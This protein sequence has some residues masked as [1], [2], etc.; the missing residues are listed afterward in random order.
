MKIAIVTGGNR[1]I[2]YEIVRGLFLSGQF[3]DVYLTARTPKDGISAVNALMKD[4]ESDNKQDISRLRFHQ[5]DLTDPQ[6][7][8]KFLDHLNT[9]HNGTFDVLVQNAAIAFKNAATEPFHDQAEVTLRTN[10]W[11]TL[12]LMK[13]FA[14]KC[15]E[16]GRIVLMS[17]FCSQSAQFQFKPNS[18]KNPIAKE[19]YLVNNE[20]TLERM[21]QLARQFV[22]D[23]KAGINE[24]NGWPTSAYGVSKLFTNCITR[25][26]A[27]VAVTEKNGVLINCCC[28]GFVKTDMSSFSENAPKYPPEGAEKAIALALLPSGLLG[29]QGCY[30]SD[31]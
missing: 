23:C 19:L 17:S 30:I 15:N 8:D 2:G 7:M 6:S 5:M 18:F 13:R 20:L 26:F 4:F 31:A 29:P 24:K 3:S 27:R 10:F 28:P 9:E 22:S 16:N 25:I 12:D 14:P 11:G 1:G 21:E